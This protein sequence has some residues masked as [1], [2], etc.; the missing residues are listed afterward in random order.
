MEGESKQHAPSCPGKVNSTMWPLPARLGCSPAELFAF[1]GAGGGWER[2]LAGAA[3][4][5]LSA[6]QAQPAGQASGQ[7]SQETARCG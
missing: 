7:G 6:K 2:A 1:T 3:A 5:P 4:A